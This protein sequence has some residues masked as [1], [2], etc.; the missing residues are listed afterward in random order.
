MPKIYLLDVC[1]HIIDLQQEVNGDRAT[2]GGYYVDTSILLGDCREYVMY[3]TLDMIKTKPKTDL[4]KII[5]ELIECGSLCNS[6][7]DRLHAGFFF[8][9]SQMLALEHDVKVSHGKVKTRKDF[10]DSWKRTRRELGL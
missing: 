7:G 1:K 10:E 5:L 8:G 9:L 6:K 2:T 3:H 4:R